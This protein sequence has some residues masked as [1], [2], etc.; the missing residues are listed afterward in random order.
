M[1]APKSRQLSRW[2]TLR[3]L[4][5]LEKADS[6][7]VSLY[8]PP[9]QPASEVEAL[10]AAALHAR[11]LPPD[12]LKQ[13]SPSPTGAVVFWGADRKCLA[14]PPFPV[15]ERKVSAGY[16]VAPL[17]SLLQGDLVVA[18]ILVRLGAYAI[19]VFQGEKLISSKVGT[20]NVHGR[21]KKGGSS[22]HRYERHREKQMEYLFERVCS[23]MRE[24]LEPHLDQLDYVIYGGERN[25]LL[26]FRK[27]CPF[28]RR[29]SDRTLSSVLN[30]HEPRQETLHTAIRDA[31]SSQVIEWHEDEGA[32]PGEG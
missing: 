7:A 12:L 15:R 4:D 1:L 6:A 29:V 16:D 23:H 18:L 11:E 27:Q 14:L 28:S 24:H 5:E 13:L 31:W 19:G 10:L 30:V 2:E 17:R 3:L 26:A 22:Q 8:F 25:T 20:G 9:D 32:A 21:H